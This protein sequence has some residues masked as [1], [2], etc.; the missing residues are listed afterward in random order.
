MTCM[1]LSL[2]VT[3]A[4]AEPVS[5]L[6]RAAAAAAAVRPSPQPPA[7]VVTLSDWTFPPSITI[8][9][10]GQPHCIVERD[11]VHYNQVTRRPPHWFRLALLIM[12]ND[13]N[14]I[15]NHMKKADFTILSFRWNL[16]SYTVH[17]IIIVIISISMSSYL[18]NKL[19][20][21]DTK[22]CFHKCDR[23]CFVS[24]LLRAVR[25]HFP[26]DICLSNGS[27]VISNSADL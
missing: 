7:G 5:H 16:F 14:I 9:G 10:K 6:T 24:R 23:L 15:S 17:F 26:K 12:S 1:R 18:V 19:T 21:L 11:C 3:C 22:C 25:Q 27:P 13:L 2:R 8:T 20:R 4:M